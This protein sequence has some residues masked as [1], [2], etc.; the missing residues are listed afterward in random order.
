MQ[1]KLQFGRLEENPAKLEHFT[2][3]NWPLLL[4]ER[5]VCRL[6]I[7]HIISAVDRVDDC[8]N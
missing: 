1:N 8:P 5:V 6:V 3:A 2:V 4:L 7:L